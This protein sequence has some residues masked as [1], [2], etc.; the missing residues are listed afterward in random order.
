MESLEYNDNQIIS[1]ESA[2]VLAKHYF[3]ML[4]VL[5]TSPILTKQEKTSTSEQTEQ[6]EIV[7]LLSQILLEIKEIKNQIAINKKIRLS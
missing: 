3:E 6:A 1:D 2:R 7:A 5:K 4:E